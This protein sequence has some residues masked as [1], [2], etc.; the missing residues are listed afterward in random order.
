METLCTEL[1][2]CEGLKPSI[3]FGQGEGLEGG[4]GDEARH[5]SAALGERPGLGA[6]HQ[7]QVQLVLPQVLGDSLRTEAVSDHV[8][9][10]VARTNLRIQTTENKSLDD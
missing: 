5:T 10:I 2:H 6:V 7:H 8:L 4:L 9:L 1:Y 3:C